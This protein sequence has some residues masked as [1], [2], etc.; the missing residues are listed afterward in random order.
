[1]KLAAF[2]PRPHRIAAPARRDAAPPS[3]ARAQL[4]GAIGAAALLR[5][6]KHG[7]RGALPRAQ[8]PTLIIRDYERALL[9]LLERARPHV[10]RLKQE[11]TT[12]VTIIRARRGDAA[13][14][15]PGRDPDVRRLIEETRRQ[16]SGAIGP[17]DVERLAARYADQ[18]QDFQ[19]EQLGRQIHAAFGADVTF[20]DPGLAGMIGGFARDNAGLI[21]SIPTNFATEVE[22]LV[23]QA[24]FAPRL[25]PA[26]ARDIDRR[27]S[28]GQSRA[29]LIARDQIS[30]LVGNVNH[31]RQRELGVSR[32]TWRTVEDDRVRDEHDDLDGEVFDYDDP[33]EEG[34]PSEAVN[35]RCSA[36]PVLDDLLGDDEEAAGG[37][38]ETAPAPDDD[39]EGDDFDPMS[40]VGQMAPGFAELFGGAAEAG[41]AELGATEL[42]PEAEGAL[43]AEVPAGFDLTLEADGSS[44]FDANPEIVRGVP[45]LDEA[46]SRAYRKVAYVIRP[47]EFARHEVYGIDT[48][49]AKPTDARTASILKAWR[50]GHNV[51]AVEI[52]VDPRG[53]YFIADGNHRVWAATLDG[54]REI[55]ARFRPSALEAHSMDPMTQGLHEALGTNNIR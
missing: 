32:F 1:M 18:T 54:D 4:L 3:S 28:V 6:R 16:M 5:G 8:R 43:A 7:R 29:R 10:E 45:T 37:D 36:E 11:A 27:F 15:P 34:L 24:V 41:G 52:D 35:C 14:D 20:R 17:G 55:A 2:D 30:K 22:G 21:T 48:G 50:Q 46:R 42:A 12:L 51:P 26:L 23:Q 19:R 13:G 31:A 53:R 40:V 33:P 47:S 25:H 9:A 44:V 49:G 39:D 38:D